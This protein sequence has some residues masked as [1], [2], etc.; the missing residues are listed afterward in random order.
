IGSPG[1]GTPPQAGL[2]STTGGS[3]PNTVVVHTFDVT[4]NAASRPFHLQIGCGLGGDGSGGTHATR[5]RLRGDAPD[6]RSRGTGR[7]KVDFGRDL[8]ACSYVATV[9]GAGTTGLVYTTS[10]DNGVNV[11]TTD[12]TGV[13]TNLPFHLQTTC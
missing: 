10:G 9:E 5:R 1:Q 8:S 6:A 4:G 11:K 12:A 2:V 3:D 13:L 7:R